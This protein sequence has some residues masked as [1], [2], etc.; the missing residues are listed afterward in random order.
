MK[1][2]L[3]LLAIQPEYQEFAVPELKAILAPLKIPFPTLFADS[4]PLPDRHFLITHRSLLNFPYITL[5]VP[6]FELHR[7]CKHRVT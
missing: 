3:A 1:K 5:T 4:A 2:V 7:K 6:D